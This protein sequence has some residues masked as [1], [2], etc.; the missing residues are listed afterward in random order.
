VPHTPI[1]LFGASGRMGRAIRASLAEFPDASL[2]ACVARSAD[3]IACPPGCTWVT[4][5]DL[6]TATAFPKESVVIDVSLA[7]GTAALLDWLER[8]PRPLVSAT[9][10]LSE[11]DEGRIRALAAR[12]AVLRARNLS[13]GNSIASGMLLSVPDPAKALFEIDLIEHHH[14]AKRD[15][16]SGTAL[17]WAS[18]LKPSE[19]RMHSIRSGTA[20]GTHRVLFA[21]AGET[22]EVVHSVQDRAVF[23]RGALRAAGF[24]CGKRPGLYTVEQML[25][26]P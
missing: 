19:V 26:G 3:D 8:S 22:L 11:A 25:G 16:P 20:V 13:A 24:L 9:T 7:A 4:P 6:A 21:G 2:V 1:I 12:T 14:P 17:A 18:L 15:A 5:G 23:A 10:G